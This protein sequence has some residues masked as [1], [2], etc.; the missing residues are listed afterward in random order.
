MNQHAVII[1]GGIGGLLAAHALAD[2]FSRVTIL[3]RDRYPSEAS[4]PAP[5]SRRGAPQSRCLHLLMAAGA[6]AF[7]ELMPGWR[8]EVGARGAIAFDASADAVTRFPDG[9][10][11]RAHSGITTYAC[12]RALLEDVLR[13]SLA[14]KST[15]HVREGQKVVGLLSDPFGTRVSGVRTS[16]PQ[17]STASDVTADVVVDASGRGSRLPA[18][19]HRLPDRLPLQVEETI[20]EVR[21]QYVSRWFHL[22]PGDAPNWQCLSIAPSRHTPRSAMMMRAEGKCWGVVLLAPAGEQLPSDDRAFLDF[23]ASLGDGKLRGALDRATPVSPI[24]HY[25]AAA[26]RLRHY[27]RVTT[28]PAR[29]VALGDAVCALDPYF[30][31]GMTA[32]ARGALLLKRFVDQTGFEAA[33]SIEFQT[34]LALLNRQPWQLAT[35]CDADGCMIARDERRRSRLYEAAPSSPDVSLALLAVQHLLHPAESLNGDV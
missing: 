22:E 7:D 24:H 12:S 9:W 6:A 19:L 23:T 29:L 2:G 27:D 15:V 10:L 31:L 33:A 13:R 4:T 3:E 18:W 17:G 16:T 25:G 11:P 20:V 1:G 8:S 34:A 14:R 32:A 26:N 5:L 21:T 28:W 30:G 35:G